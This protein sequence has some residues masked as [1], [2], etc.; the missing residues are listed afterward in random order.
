MIVKTQIHIDTQTHHTDAHIDTDKHTHTHTDPH[1]NTHT[2]FQ[3]AWLP[4]YMYNV[5]VHLY[6]IIRSEL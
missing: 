1:T 6:Y 4:F 3:C 5:Q 2:H